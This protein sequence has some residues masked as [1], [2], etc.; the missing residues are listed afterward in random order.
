MIKKFLFPLFMLMFL[1]ITGCIKETYNMN[2]L[3]DKMHYSPTLAMAVATGDI[4]LSDLIKSNDTIVFDNDNFIRVVFKKDSII[5]FKL[6]DYYDLSSMVSFKK[7]YKMGELKIADF[8]DTVAVTLNT[9]SQSFTTPGLRTAFLLLDDGAQH[10][11]PSFPLT[12]IGEKSF[13]M[14]TNFQNALFSS[15]T[16]EISVKN[17]LTAPLNDIKVKLYNSTGHTQIGSE[18]TI[19]AIV[20]GATKSATMD[21]AGKTVTNSIIA[22]IVLTGSPGASNVIIDM[23]HTVQVGIYGSN[24]KVQSGKM[25]I[26]LQTINSLDNLDTVS[27][28]P[29]S[30]VEIEKLKINDGTLG[31]HVVS[32]SDISASFTLT[33]PTVLREGTPITKTIDIDPDA[34]FDGNISVDN[35][36]VD[37]STDALQNYNRLPVDYSIIVGSGG[38]MI[39]FNKDDSIHLDLN[40]PD[41]D[42]DYVKGY[43]GQ[44][45]KQI[46]PDSI[47]TELDDI[48]NHISGSFHISNPSITINYSNSFGIPI[49]VTLNAT[50]KRKAQTVNLGLDP[51]TI[52]YPNSL[53][54]RD[55]SST[56]VIDSINSELPDLVSLPPTEI[57]FSGSAKMNP[58]GPSG[59]RNNYVFGNSRF[60]GSLEVEVPMELWINNLQ[61]SDT[62][63]NFLASKDSSDS[64]FKPEDMDLFRLDISV[65]NGFPLGA[66]LKLILFDS[67]SHAGVDTIDATDIIEP[68]QIDAN[69]KVSGITETATS[70]DFPKDFFEAINEADKMIFVFTLNTSGGGTKDVKI[71]SNYSISFKASVVVKPDLNFK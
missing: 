28:D 44:L 6:I 61:F 14:F 20:P 25:I 53:S 51:F 47:M 67:A 21:L 50:G 17:D 40:M 65:K 19:P 46:D 32:K 55:V 68:A 49:E 34:D 23:D 24:L 59:G 22:G 27:F 62:V 35:T 16:L 43:F 15:G 8:F 57:K 1:V 3:S 58:L 45:E 7:G 10:D 33:L 30:D 70:I 60:T 29:G 38:T 71:Y 48:L 31:Y 37:L 13:D 41:P 2:K 54:P 64:P 63:D 4:T 39:D 5:N 56:F 36:E 26:P 52:A 42:L 69:G 66:S 18:M 9:I 11:F 12:D